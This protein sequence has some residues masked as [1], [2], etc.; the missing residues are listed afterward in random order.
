[1]TTLKAA[2]LFADA[3]YDAATLAS[4]IEAY[5]AVCDELGIRSRPAHLHHNNELRL[6]VALRILKAVAAGERDPHCMQ[7]LALRAIHGQE[8]DSREGRGCHNY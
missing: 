6:Q 8:N 1:M 3:P 5:A 4:M 7:L 2:E